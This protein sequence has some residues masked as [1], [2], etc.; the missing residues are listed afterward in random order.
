MPHKFIAPDGEET[1]YGE[2]YHFAMWQI[3]HENGGYLKLDKPPAELMGRNGTL[4]HRETPNGGLE[5]KLVFDDET[6]QSGNA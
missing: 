3:V 2:I 6:Q 1:K 5:F 4:A